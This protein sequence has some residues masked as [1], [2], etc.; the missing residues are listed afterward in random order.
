MNRVAVEKLVLSENDAVAAGLRETLRR[1]GAL[2]LNFIGSPGAGKAALLERTLERLPVR[3]AVAVL[4]GDIQTNNDAHRHRGGLL[5]RPLY[6]RAGGDHHRVGALQLAEAQ[7][8]S[9][10]SGGMDSATGQHPEP[11]PD[12]LFPAVRFH[13]IWRLSR[14]P[15][16]VDL[17]RGKARL[18]GQHL[19]R[20]Q[21]GSGERTR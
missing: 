2:S 3:A 12:S 20:L 4:T 8:D 13:R 6:A 15:V 16:H 14:A 21:S 18:D 7:R 1:T 17:A 9:R 11:A 10:T 19:H 5:S